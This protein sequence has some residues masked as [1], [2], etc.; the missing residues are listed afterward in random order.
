MTEPLR[1]HLTPSKEMMEWRTAVT[2]TEAAVRN[3][4]D[5]MADNPEVYTQEDM[6]HIEQAWIRVLQG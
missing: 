6:N 3:W 1:S 5:F 4:L 2:T